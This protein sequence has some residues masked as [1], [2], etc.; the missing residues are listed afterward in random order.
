MQVELEKKYKSGPLSNS[1]SFY[2][3]AHSSNPEIWFYAAA[4]LKLHLITT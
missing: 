2:F 4:A 3:S 1:Y